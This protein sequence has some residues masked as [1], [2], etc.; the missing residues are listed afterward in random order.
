MRLF[1]LFVCG[2]LILGCNR[3]D[4]ENLSQNDGVVSGD[5][6]LVYDD[7]SGLVFEV[8]ETIPFTGK[9]VWHYP[10]GK[11]KQETLFEGGREQGEERW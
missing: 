7:S 6:G 11:P 8:G 3:K 10:D 9:A 2:S 5:A 1:M 4:P